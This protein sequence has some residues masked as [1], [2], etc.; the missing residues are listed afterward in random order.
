MILKRKAR[1]A[2][3]PKK[4][5]VVQV[6]WTMLNIQILGQIVRYKIFNLAGIEILGTAKRKK[7]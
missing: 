3:K 2:V 5:I 7:L 1:N 6:L 4:K